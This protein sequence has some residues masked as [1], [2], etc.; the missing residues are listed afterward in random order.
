MYCAM[1]YAKA[2]AKVLI[3]HY[4]YTFTYLQAAYI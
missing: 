3:F 2:G 1:D 4:I